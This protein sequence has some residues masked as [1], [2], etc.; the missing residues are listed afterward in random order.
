MDILPLVVSILSAGGLILGL[1]AE[2]ALTSYSHNKLERLLG[3]EERHARVSAK[4]KNYDLLVLTLGFYNTFMTVLLVMSIHTAWRGLAA[5][6]TELIV[7]AVTFAIL[8]IGLYGL[9]RCIV[10]QV[11]ERTL[12]LLL[13]FI[14][15]IGRVLGPVA[16]SVQVVAGAVAHLIGAEKEP[17][18]DA[19]EDILDA[20]AE[21]EAEGVLE[22]RDADLIEK[23]IEFKDSVVREVMTPRT[24]LACIEKDARFDDVVALIAEHGHSRI[25]VFDGNRDNI[26]G[27]VYVKEV[28]ANV[29]AVRNGTS[30]IAA[31][32]HKPV[33]VPETKNVSDLLHEFQQARVQIAIVLDEFG[34]T[35]GLVTVED[36]VE[37]IVG[38][39]ED[40]ADGADGVNEIARLDENEVELDAQIDIDYL[41][42]QLNLS[43]PDDGDYETLGGF[44][45]AT[46][47]KVPKK[48]ENVVLDGVSFEVTDADE[49]KVKRVRLRVSG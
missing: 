9:L 3:D 7:F 6:R 27:I 22:E 33:F 13:E 35:S 34:G 16:R 37:E 42:E 30:A 29:D 18:D 21:G 20:V 15:M 24:Q 38:E 47:G 26:V 17:V 49:R 45:S 14:A 36:I 44:L 2:S 19:V 11:A 4:L 48:G 10:A 46:L 31:L 43:I 28:L 32:M 1:A 8:G 5:D 23:I 40:V 25:P 41:N 12:V 39:L